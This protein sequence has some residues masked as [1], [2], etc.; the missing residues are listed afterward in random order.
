MPLS[1]RDSDSWRGRLG[2]RDPRRLRDDP[3]VLK[4]ELA[5]LRRKLR[6]V[7]SERDGLRDQLKEIRRDLEKALGRMRVSRWR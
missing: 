7:E 6:Q 1:G 4:R 2:E 3:E 5:D